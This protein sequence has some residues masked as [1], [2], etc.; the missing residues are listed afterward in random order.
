M[1]DRCRCLPLRCIGAIAQLGERLNG[2]QEVAGSI[3]AGSTSL[4]QGFGWQVLVLNDH[5]HLSSAEA[6]A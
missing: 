5:V 3:P 2:I 1:A 4:R 6:L